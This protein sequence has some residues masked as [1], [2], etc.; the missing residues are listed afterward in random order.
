MPVNS[1][2]IELLK[3]FLLSLTVWKSPGSLKFLNSRIGFII[4]DAFS[5]LCYIFVHMNTFHTYSMYMY[6]HVYLQEHVYVS[7]RDS[8]DQLLIV[9]FFLFLTYSTHFHKWRLIRA[10]H[11]SYKLGFLKLPMPG[12]PFHTHGFGKK[13]DKNL[14][15]SQK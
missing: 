14:E 13:K 9:D 15:G 8:F 2:A 11:Q 4:K 6:V 1:I 10:V 5:N 12:L 7:N 3:F